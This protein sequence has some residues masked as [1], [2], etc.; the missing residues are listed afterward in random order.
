MHAHEEDQ[1]M[2]DGEDLIPPRK[3]KGPLFLIFSMLFVFSIGLMYLDI[4]SPLEATKNENS[5]NLDAVSIDENE[6]YESL[7]QSLIPRVPRLEQPVVGSNL[8]YFGPFNLPENGLVKRFSVLGNL[9]Y[10]HHLIVLAGSDVDEEKGFHSYGGEHILYAWARSGLSSA[11][12]FDFHQD[13]GML[14]GP[15]T[16]SKTIWINP[17]YEVDASMLDDPIQVAINITYETQD[18]ASIDIVK[19]CSA[20]S[21]GVPGCQAILNRL[22]GV[23]LV[24][25]SN[26]RLKPRKKDVYVTSKCR[27]TRDATIFAYR[28]HGHAAGRLWIS[29]IFRNDVLVHVLVNR[30]VQDPQIFHTL[31]VPY[32]LLENDVVELQCHYNTM[33]RTQITVPGA[34][35]TNGDEMCNHYLMFTPHLYGVDS[36]C[37]RIRGPEMGRPYNLNPFPSMAKNALPATLG[38]V[39]SVAVSED[40]TLAFVLARRTNHFDSTEIISL[41]T[42]FCI[43]TT[44]G[45]VLWSSCKDVFVVPHGLAFDKRGYL[46]AT[47]VKLMVVFQIDIKSGKILST[48]GEQNV[49]GADF[50]FFNGPADVAID[51]KRDL[52]YVSDG[53]FNQRVVV[54]SLSKLEYIRE[55]G[56]H[57]GNVHFR[58]AHSIA[59]DSA[60]DSV[61]VADRDN[62]RIQVFDSLGKPKAVWDCEFCRGPITHFNAQ[63]SAVAYSESLNL[64]YVIEGAFLVTRDP[65]T[66]DV[67]SSWGESTGWPHDIEVAGSQV[68]VAEMDSQIVKRYSLT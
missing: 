68:F 38:E 37:K 40:G 16:N 21:S 7:S 57:H 5:S 59:V 23:E 62:Q 53:Y 39:T 56:L 30:T 55:W 35:V 43:N 52:L 61:F 20:S 17:H 34:N 42:L 65:L 48:L 44:S 3:R 10:L 9:S 51:Y 31:P 26:F 29:Q 32:K 14:I 64:L 67:L 28:N 45:S 50:P 27:L 58:V 24:Q 2:G 22:A 63:L 8:M 33:N 47:D 4:H 60:G 15:D 19:K 36:I 6:D 49:P 11:G 13:V 66:G 25:T 41:D 54:Y 46:W 12:T 18:N 1:L